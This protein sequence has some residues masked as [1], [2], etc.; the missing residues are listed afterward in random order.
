MEDNL[1][2]QCSKYLKCSVSNCPLS[3]NYPNW[4]I[5]LDDL[6]KRCTLT[7][8]KRLKIVSEN[9]I[10]LEYGGLTH[11]ENQARIKW[12]ALPEAEKERI[13]QKVSNI[14]VNSRKKVV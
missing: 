9:N 12:E 14:R 6:E 5:T 3:I 2:E 13:R 10:V 7:K 4:D 8:E 1:F 11:R